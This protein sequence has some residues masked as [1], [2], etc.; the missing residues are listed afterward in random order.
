[1]TTHRCTGESTRGS[2]QALLRR[3]QDVAEGK[4]GSALPW[5]LI[6][7]GAA[8]G[9]FHAGLQTRLVVTSLAVSARCA[10]LHVCL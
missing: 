9:C 7:R 10:A 4:T 6:W 2:R 5:H 3:L 1:M 8:W